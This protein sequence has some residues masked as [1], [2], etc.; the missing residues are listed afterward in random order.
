M[1]PLTGDNYDTWV[2]QMKAFMCRV[3]L[4]DYVN[5]TI[6]KP[7]VISAWKNVLTDGGRKDKKAMSEIILNMHLSQLK[8]VK[9]VDTSHTDCSRS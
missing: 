6:L 5:G 4:L 8:H 3:D 2:I 1:E 7:A 9:S